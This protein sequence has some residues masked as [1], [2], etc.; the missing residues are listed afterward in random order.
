MLERLSPSVISQ[1]VTTGQF[2]DR[3][4]IFPGDAHSVVLN[5][6]RIQA[7]VFETNLCSQ[8]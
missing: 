1:S 3:F 4:V 5:L 6:D 8:L 7:M 2:T